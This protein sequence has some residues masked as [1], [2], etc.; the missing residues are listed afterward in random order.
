MHSIYNTES[1]FLSDPERYTN[2]VLDGDVAG[3][4]ELLTNVEVEKRV[5]RRSF[6]KA[7]TYGQDIQ[8]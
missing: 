5:L 2:L 1:K 3:I 4:L 7:S 6:L 8:V